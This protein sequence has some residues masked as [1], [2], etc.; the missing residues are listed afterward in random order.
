MENSYK[1]TEEALKRKAEQESREGKLLWDSPL[2]K[3]IY[4][5]DEG[6]REYHLDVAGMT[7]RELYFHVYNE[8]YDPEDFAS[9][10]L[11]KRGIEKDRPCNQCQGSGCPNCNGY[12][13]IPTFE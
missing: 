10:A 6:T 5:I 11:K 9:K 1:K 3:F 7:D 4:N 8:D 2:G 12:G 13:T